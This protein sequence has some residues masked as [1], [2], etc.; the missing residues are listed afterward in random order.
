M[1]WLTFTSKIIQALAWPV[2]IVII[3][4]LLRKQILELIPKITKLEAG[5]LKAEFSSDV[6][7][8]LVDV[9]EINLA[10]TN[11]T[12]S[13]KDNKLS[14]I[15]TDE[16]LYQDSR[17]VALW[18][19][20]AINPASGIAD[21]WKDIEYVLLE[22]IRTRGVFIPHRRIDSVGVWINAIASAQILPIETI[23]VINDLYALRNKVVNAEFIATPDAAQDYLKA[24]QRL[25]RVLN[26]YA[27]HQVN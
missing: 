11:S 6:K 15:P 17:S 4:F 24:A 1:D 5:P 14:F 26:S 23:S 2:S 10:S 27:V 16:F 21:A 18:R 3:I 9:E 8:A 20:A 22:I 12:R 25:I 13:T 19:T 7:R